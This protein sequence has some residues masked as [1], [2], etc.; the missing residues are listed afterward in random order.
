MVVLTGT[1]RLIRLAVRR[2]R[3]IVPVTATVVIALVAGSLPALTEAYPDVASQI[4]YVTSAAVSSVG[5]IFSGTVQGANLGSI[6]MAELYFFVAIII[7]LMSMFIISRHT[8]YNEE[9][10]ASDL[11]GSSII[12]RSAQLS[13]AVF[14]SVVI[15]LMIGIVLFAVLAS[16]DGLSVKGAAFFGLSIV[17][18]GMFF[19]AVAAIAA[20]L[21]DYRRGSN[22][23]GIAV[24]T[25]CFIVRAMGDALGDLSADGFSVTANWLTWLSP[26]GWGYQVLPFSD[27]RLFPILLLVSGAIVL[28]YTAYYLM[29]R[30]DIGSSI[31]TAKKG[32][33]HASRYLRS[34]TGLAYKLQ[35]SQFLM[36]LA[37][38]IVVGSMITVVAHDY[39]TTFEQSE[40]F[41]NFLGP[42]SGSFTDSVIASMF[43]L[44]SGLLA[45]YIVSMVIR[46]SQ[47]ESS[48]RLEQLLATAKTR[49]AW[50]ASHISVITIG[51]ILLFLA[52]GL[53][54]ALSYWFA[55]DIRET[56][57][58][59][60]IVSAAIN[61]P[62]T[63]LFLSLCVLL[64]A[65]APKVC[66]SAAWFIYGYIALI[67][68]LAS[69]FKWP[70]WTQNFSPFTHTPIY[71]GTELNMSPIYIMT[72]TSICLL[73]ISLF[74]FQRRDLLL[75]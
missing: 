28:T 19:T 30:R 54:G 3:I 41:I 51:S 64:F 10:G 66:K 12:G 42:M 63:L 71:P 48:G 53:F 70:Q 1:K 49:S 23:I 13:A 52:M 61:I 5:R 32:P 22:T 34:L 46:M 37:G 74:L 2:D 9:I 33:A 6:V 73:L 27:N 56:A 36:W 25:I 50:L 8:R 11:L 59:D 62:A 7:A 4:S 60:I 21:S 26:L 14:F 40:M 35:R 24:L 18:V 45:A 47:E 67:G 29:E 20:Q 17:S 31:F 57:L 16:T 38:F 75:K 15:N 65:I 44:V 68:T 58:P 43:P 55:A 39:R 69:I 72:V